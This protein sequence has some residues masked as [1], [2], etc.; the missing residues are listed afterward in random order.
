M[1]S[2]HSMISNMF[3]LSWARDLIA[4]CDVMWEEKFATGLRSNYNFHFLTLIMGLGVTLMDTKSRY[5]QF[6]VKLNRPI[7]NEGT[8]IYKGD[9]AITG[10]FIHS[11]AVQFFW[12]FLIHLKINNRKMVALEPFGSL[13]HKQHC[14]TNRVVEQWKTKFKKIIDFLIKMRFCTPFHISK[15]LR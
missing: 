2:I 3:G 7:C 11:P 5:Y 13:L 14:S 10:Q 4:S 12:N 1:S 8:A 9:Y 15:R 6:N